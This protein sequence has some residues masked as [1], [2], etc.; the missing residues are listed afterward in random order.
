[1]ASPARRAAWPLATVTLLALA[2]ACGESDR[3]A[4]DGDST[5]PPGPTVQG[6]GGGD[7]ATAGGSFDPN[8][9]GEGGATNG[10]TTLGPSCA[11]ETKLAERL[12]IDLVFMMDTSGSMGEGTGVAGKTKWDAV[13]EA[14]T[15]FLNDPQSAGIGVGIQYFPVAEAGVPA[16]CTSSAQ[17]NGF[18]PCSVKVCAQNG[19]IRACD[20][21]AD[22]P[23]TSTPCGRLGTCSLDPNQLCITDVAGYGC[24]SGKGS[25]QPTADGYCDRRDSCDVPKYTAPVVDVALLPGAAAA[26]TASLQGREPD[27][28][29][30]SA[31]ALAGVIQRAKQV[32][33]AN[34]TH[35]VVAV[36]MTDGF[37]T[38]CTPMDIPTIAQIAS[39]GVGG[40]PSIKTFVIGVFSPGE[41]TEAQTSLDA[42]ATGG[43]TAPAFIISSNQNVTQGFLAALDTIR[44]S[45]L[46]CEYAIPVPEAGTP[47]YNKLN[48]RYTTGAGKET[49]LPYAKNLAG[50]SP[51]GGWYYDADPLTAVPKKIILCASTCSTLKGDPQG[52]VDILLGC[53][54][55]V[56]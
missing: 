51:A 50:C 8:D 21:S 20:T 5:F 9:N 45:S 32:A 16:S 49:I 27:G 38:R 13:R 42:I 34:P 47:D 33:G 12:P 2:A 35:K 11:A 56:N 52:K 19:P 30:P 23:N 14:M 24:P 6:D 46:T 55:N 36:L 43:G 37:P 40:T 25:C 4:Q 53:K 17:C 39:A 26:L 31:P 48:V 3:P 28:L 18:G 1:M 10:S 29:T 54:T 22:C 7:D 15:A 41:A 44:G